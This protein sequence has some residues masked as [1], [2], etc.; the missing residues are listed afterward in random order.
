MLV[1]SFQEIVNK[2]GNKPAIKTAAVEHSFHDVSNG[3]DRIAAAILSRQVISDMSG[4]PGVVSLLFGHGAGMILS[5]LGVIKSGNAYVPLD[6]NYPV[7]RLEYILEDSDTWLIVTDNG[8]IGLA[9]KLSAKSCGRIQTLNVDTIGKC[10]ISGQTERKILENETAY[11][12]YT[13]GSTGKPKGV[14]QSHRNINHFIG[15]YAKDLKITHQ[16]RLTMISAF[17]H[18]AAVMDVY[19]GLLTG[20]TLFPLD[21]RTQLNDIDI[22]DWLKKEKISIY[23]SVPTLY[24]HF[25][26]GFDEKTDFP[27]L[28]HIVLGG[29]AVVE[30]DIKAFRR[31]FPGATLMNLYGQSE[32]SYNSGHFIAH[33]TSLNKVTLGKV[34]GNTSILVVDEQ[35]VEVAPLGVGE[36]VVNSDHVALGY[37]KDPERT[38]KYFTRDE[39]LGKL[40]W[41]GDLGRLQL[42]GSIEFMGRKDFQVKIRGFRVDLGEIESRLLSHPLV[43][44]AAVIVK[45]D[46]EDNSYLWAYLTAKGQLTD[47]ELRDYSA[48]ELP[49]HMVPSYFIILDEMP[50]TSTNKIDRH[51]LKQIQHERQAGKTILSPRDETEAKL[52]DIWQGV[53]SVK[54]ISINDNFFELGGHS[55]KAITLSS[56]VHRELGKELPLRK[57]FEQPTI[58]GQGRY[59]KEQ[60]TGGYSGIEVVGK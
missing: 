15:N 3:S 25:V 56:R 27:D 12:I 39:E 29:E 31:Y 10:D 54:E 60:G 18:D 21:V 49:D 55:L 43:K 22:A 37:W 41:T 59:L 36:I 48:E 1:K 45:Q 51:K 47:G 2:Y 8:N 50:L 58:E 24:R 46:D 42:D 19:A 9:E 13:S 7:K 44:H 32:S 17:N 53:L 33:D 38:E 35:G 30:Q 14:Y 16:D 11:I 20:A 26:G 57:I 23:H 28:R 52:L 4:K 34:T 5:L 6:I 40:Y